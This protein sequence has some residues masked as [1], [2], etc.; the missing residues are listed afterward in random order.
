MHVALVV[1]GDAVRL[2]LY[3]LCVLA[4]SS[5]NWLL[6]WVMGLVMIV[7]DA[8]KIFARAVPTATR[9]VVVPVA[10]L[11]TGAWCVALFARAAVR[12]LVTGAPIEIPVLLALGVAGA[13]CLA[14]V[15]MALCRLPL[16][17][18]GRS[19]LRSAT[20]VLVLIGVVAAFRARSR[21]STA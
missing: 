19:A 7:I 8:V 1:A 14:V 21:T 2:A 20:A 4:V 3:G 12:Y 10:G 18:C 15:W 11:A 6:G 5:L 16:A 9:V 13:G 17:D